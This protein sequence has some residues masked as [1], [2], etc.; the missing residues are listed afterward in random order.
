[1]FHK[2]GVTNPFIA[3]LETQLNT[4]VSFANATLQSTAELIELN[5]GLGRDS[6]RDSAD[7]QKRLLA[8]SDANQYLASASV[9]A[10]E[11]YERGLS[12]TRDLASIFTKTYTQFNEAAG[13]SNAK[14]AT[15]TKAT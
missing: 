2:D 1:M 14:A 13:T 6:L 10:R 7:A 8:A 3:S 11:N 5:M 12:Y 15:K 4:Y 9:L